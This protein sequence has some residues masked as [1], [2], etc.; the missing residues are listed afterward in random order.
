MKLAALCFHSLGF[1]WG[2]GRAEAF[3]EGRTATAEFVLASLDPKGQQQ[4]VRQTKSALLSP[5]VC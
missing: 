2:L 3:Q 5:A 1:S 4:H